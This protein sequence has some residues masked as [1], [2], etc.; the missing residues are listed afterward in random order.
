MKKFFPYV[1]FVCL[2]A[3]TATSGLP[4]MAGGCS[5]NRNKTAEIKCAKDD[6]DCQSTKANKLDPKKLKNFNS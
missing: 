6:T 4:V 2:T 3:F 1:A 5:S